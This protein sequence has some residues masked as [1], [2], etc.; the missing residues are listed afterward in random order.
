MDISTLIKLATK[1]INSLKTAN[2]NIEADLLMS[3]V[4]AKPRSWL[5]AHND[6]QLT[7][8]EEKKFNNLVKKRLLNQPI[9]Y[10]IGEQEFMGLKFKVN[11]NTLIPRPETELLVETALQNYAKNTLY[12]DVG[13]GSGAIIISLA[14]KLKDKAKYLAFDISQ[15]ALVVAKK[16]SQLNQVDK[17][18]SFRS[19]DLLTLIIKQNTLL[20]GVEQL[21]ICANLPYV[22]TAYLKKLTKPDNKS[23]AFEPALALAGGADGLDLYRRLAKEIKTVKNKNKLLK[24]VCLAEIQPNQANKIKNILGA[25][26]LILKDYCHKDRL[27]VAEF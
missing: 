16:N 21:V 6:Y 10:L 4:L 22:P 18:I 9:A 24:I 17:L 5:I 12:L 14:N 11:K 15:K 26:T 20:R 2:P 19:S 3:A 1:R 27:A 8:V 25:K 7:K 13:T 23:L